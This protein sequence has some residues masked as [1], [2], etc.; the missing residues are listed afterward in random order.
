MRHALFGDA[1]RPFS[2][3]VRTEVNTTVV[4]RFTLFI[5]N[6]VFNAPGNMWWARA[7]YVAT[8]VALS[9]FDTRFDFDPNYW[10]VE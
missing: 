9:T 1:T 8:L 7:D 5:K 10:F 3:Y 4:G 6:R 2:G